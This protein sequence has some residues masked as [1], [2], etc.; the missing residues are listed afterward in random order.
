[1]LAKL[2]QVRKDH[3]SSYAQSLLISSVDFCS[4]QALRH[5]S[6]E[7]SDEENR[8]L[9]PFLT[10]SADNTSLKDLKIPTRLTVID[11]EEY[12]IEI[13]A[14]IK[15]LKRDGLECVFKDNSNLQPFV[16]FDLS[17]ET[18]TMSITM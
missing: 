5:K 2:C 12:R 17:L 18:Q 14:A 10:A 13:A 15:N 8:R 16:N 3:N 7:T 6:E 4:N 11:M 9:L 1:M